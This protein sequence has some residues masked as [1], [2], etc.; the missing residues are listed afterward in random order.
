MQIEALCF[1][2]DGVIADTETIWFDCMYRFC[3]ER[4]CGANWELLLDC[5]GDGDVRLLAHVR[6]LTGLEDEEI[7]SRVRADFYDRAEHLGTRPGVHAYLD[8]AK[9]SGLKLA[10]VSNSRGPY[11]RRWLARLGLSD[12]FDCVVTRDETLPIKPAPHLYL[13]AV[14]LL[15]VAPNRAIA[16]EDSL[17]GLR[18]ALSAGLCAVGFPNALSK[19]AMRRHFSFCFDLAEVPPE[20]LISCAERRYLLAEQV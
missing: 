20:T 18:A 19:E 12:R 16:I 11:I 17:I 3:R 13:R 10:L 15:G 2:F 14:Q 9:A 7:L 5:V 6:E 4:N 8:Y 1:D